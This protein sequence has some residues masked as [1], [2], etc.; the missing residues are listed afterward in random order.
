MLDGCFNIINYIDTV[1]EYAK[2]E[3]TLLKPFAGIQAKAMKIIS[4]VTF[5]CEC[6]SIYFIEHKHRIGDVLRLTKMNFEQPGLREWALLTIRNLCERI[7]VS[8]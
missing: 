5:K 3:P 7:F 4:N 8:F 6:A 1:N 2:N